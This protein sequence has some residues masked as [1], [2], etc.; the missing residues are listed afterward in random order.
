MKR[1]RAPLALLLALA[2]AVAACGGDSSSADDSSSDTG[3]AD[4]SSA[5]ADGPVTIEHRYGSTTV[6]ETPQRIVSLNPQWT[7]V[8]VAMDGP[9]V[10]AGLDP[11]VEGGRYPWQTD[12]PESVED[13][14]V[15]NA[16]PYEAVAALQPDLILISFYADT[17]A[18]YD[19]LSAI[20][21]TVPLLGQAGVDRWEDMA[22][23]AGEV[24]GEPEKADELIAEAEQRTADLRAELPG[25][26][27]ETF[28]LANYVPGDAIYVVAD[29]EDGAST[30]FAD[31]GL[32]LDPELP[33]LENGDEGRAQLSLEQ[34]DLLD[35]DL[36]VML[37]NGTDTADIPGYDALPA[38]RSGAVSLLDVADVTGLNTPSPLSIPYALERIRPALEAAAG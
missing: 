5:T 15:A 28:A 10:A 18:V 29:P 11:A 34:I 24:L 12:I 14:P 26:E 9:M 21:P 32:E 35:A 13:I 33:A 27:G 19:T 37:T 30:F 31:L 23:V 4:G 36:L 1:S 3:A 7:D 16:I 8:M 2:L 17:Q 25:L 38:V 6:D 20:A 22:T